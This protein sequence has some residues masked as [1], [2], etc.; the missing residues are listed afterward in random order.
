MELPLELKG[1]LEA[2][3]AGLPQ[4]QLAHAAQGFSLRYRKESG[5]GRRL[6]TDETEAAAY[7]IA[8]MPATF[9][10]ALAALR[11]A[12]AHAKAQILTLLDAGAGTGA[13]CWAAM[14]A[15]PEIRRITCI[16]RESA[17]RRT[18]QRLAH[19]GP[20]PLRN[21]EWLS[22]DLTKEPPGRKADIVIASY[23]LGE[24]AEEDRGKAAEWLWDAAEKLLLIVEPGTPAGFTQLGELRARLLNCGAHI[25]APCPH[26]GLCPVPEGDWCHF[27]CRVPR[28]RL[29]RALKGGQAPYE[30]EKFAYMAFSKEPCGRALSRCCAIRALNRAAL[31]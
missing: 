7:A 4:S 23:V 29:H 17:M 6:L 31:R 12:Q 9:G 14:E 24:M 16:E 28:S 13:A 22:A 3:A 10:A 21:A 11:G 26:E 2:L 19:A 20:D 1:A 5:G 27:T 25:A 18:G 15:L 8:R 30:D